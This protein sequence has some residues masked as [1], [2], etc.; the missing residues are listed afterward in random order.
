MTGVQAL[1][2]YQADT[3]GH[4]V[5][6]GGSFGSCTTNCI[7]FAWNS[8]SADVRPVRWLLGGGRQ[9]ACQGAAGQHRRLPAVQARG[10]HHVFFNSLGLHSYTVMRLE[11]I[12]ALARPAAAR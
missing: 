1:W 3:S 10:G 11:P 9:N 2:V 6:A 8:G 12:P 4:P 5:G 7:K